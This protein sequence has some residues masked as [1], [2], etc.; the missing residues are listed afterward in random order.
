VGGHA[1]ISRDVPPF[2][3][4]VGDRPHALAGLNRVGLRRAGIGGESM[5]ALKAAFRALFRSDLPLAERI[6]AVER[7]T[8][9]VERL[10]TFVR[11]SKRGVIGL[12]S[13]GDDVETDG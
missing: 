10:L 1:G 12:G 6:A 3:T 5:R 8:P 2:C 13:R 9:E 4:V 11:A 7:G